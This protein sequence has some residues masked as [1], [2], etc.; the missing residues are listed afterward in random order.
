MVTAAL[1]DRGLYIDS[2]LAQVNASDSVTFKGLGNVYGSL[3][4]L[5]L[6]IDNANLYG[7]QDAEVL[8]GIVHWVSQFSNTD[9]LQN[10][11]HGVVILASQIWLITGLVNSGLLPGLTSSYKL[12]PA[13]KA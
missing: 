10:D 11:L 2:S 6:M 8:G 3:V 9:S 13:P 7:D 12:T 4:P 1:F 5:G